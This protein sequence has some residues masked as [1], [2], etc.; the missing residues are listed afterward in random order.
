[1]ENTIKPRILITV[2]NVGDEKKIKEIFDTTGVPMAFACPAQG[3]APS[4]IMD[5]FG[6]SGRSKIITGGLTL[7]GRVKEIFS[8][9]SSDLSF[10]E[11]G[12]GIAFTVPLTGL[13]SH[14]LSSLER[15]NQN[16]SEGDDVKVSEKTYSAIFASCAAGYSEDV[17]EVARKA[18]AAGGTII[19]GM[20]ETSEN[21]SETLGLPRLEEQ[22]LILIVTTK[23]QKKDIMTAII[24]ECGT[25]TE[26]HTTVLSFPIEEVFGLR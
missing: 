18:G 1:M 19:K 17:F 4:A 21:L 6:L 22:D 12:K 3:T 15:E 23:E 5:I 7:K 16:I 8:R 9:L 20:R 26:A 2:S 25:S 13:Q 14:V 24:N 11:K 10:A